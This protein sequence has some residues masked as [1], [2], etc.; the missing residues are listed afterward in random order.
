MSLSFVKAILRMMRM[1]RMSL[2]TQ[3]RCKG[4]GQVVSLPGLFDPQGKRGGSCQALPGNHHVTA[5]VELTWAHRIAATA[6][7][8]GRPLI[9]DLIFCA[10]AHFLHR[11]VG[12]SR[13]QSLG[14]LSY[15]QSRQWRT[16]HH[17]T[18]NIALIPKFVYKQLF[19]AQ[20]LIVILISQ[21]SSRPSVFG[22]F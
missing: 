21:P 7:E 13:T 2:D 8:V 15:E 10:L 4:C 22:R 19:I 3:K 12:C 17:Y 20:S 5:D 11:V 1:M 18:F 6:K 9:S 14:I 16:L